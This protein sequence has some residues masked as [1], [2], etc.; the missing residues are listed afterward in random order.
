MCCN[1]NGPF[2][3]REL[4]VDHHS[5]PHSLLLRQW[6]R[7]RLQQQLR[8]HHLL[9]TVSGKHSA[10]ARRGARGRFF[11]SHPIPLLTSPPSCY[12]ICLEIFSFY[13]K[14]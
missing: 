12:T 1:N 8:H 5:D 13:H 2:R 3:R 14:I 10:P 4:L 6:E 9:L 7:L 11:S